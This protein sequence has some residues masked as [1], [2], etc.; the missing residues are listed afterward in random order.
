MERRSRKRRGSSASAKATTSYS[1]GQRTFPSPSIFTA[2]NSSERCLPALRYRCASG[3]PRPAGS[4]SKSTPTAL[5]GRRDISR[6]IRADRSSQPH[7]PSTSVRARRTD[8][9]RRR[10]SGSTS[11]G[12]RFWATIR[13]SGSAVALGQRGC[14]GRRLLLHRHQSRR[15]SRPRHPSISMREPAPLE[16]LPDH[17]QP[18][19]TAC[20]PGCVRRPPWAHRARRYRRQSESDS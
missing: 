5:S 10:R 19:T 2:T 15:P 7:P 6:F 20:S 16:P 12:S 3:P 9:G 17:R 1:D 18:R 4:R 13:S 11:G 14:G 8:T